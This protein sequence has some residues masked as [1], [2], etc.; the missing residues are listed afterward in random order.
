MIADLVVLDRQFHTQP[1]AERSSQRKGR[2][3]GRLAR[4]TVGI[5]LRS[6]HPVREI[7]QLATEVHADLI[8]VGS[9]GART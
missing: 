3:G 5:H 2:L 6:G 1:S 9:H 8:V 4:T 7:V